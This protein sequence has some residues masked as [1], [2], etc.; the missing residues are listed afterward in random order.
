MAIPFKTFL[1]W[2]YWYFLSKWIPS[3]DIAIGYLL[4]INQLSVR[5][6]KTNKKRQSRYRPCTDPRKRHTEKMCGQH[7]IQALAWVITNQW[8]L[9]PVYRRKSLYLTGFEPG[10]S[11]KGDSA[12]PPLPIRVIHH[13]NK[14]RRFTISQV[15]QTFSIISLSTV[16][17]N[18][19]VII[20]HLLLKF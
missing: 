5:V 1:L 16:S 4:L 12:R 10:S 11:G 13:T 2:T 3:I 9:Q 19:T 15:L 8:T 6:F 18:Y 7:I 17:L 20:R 14:A